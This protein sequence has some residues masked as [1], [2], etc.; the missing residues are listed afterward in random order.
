MTEIVVAN[1][2]PIGGFADWPTQIFFLFD[3]R[4]QYARH[5]RLNVELRTQLKTAQN[6]GS[7]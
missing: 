3:D 4:N 6:V 5:F 2:M 1:S 7:L